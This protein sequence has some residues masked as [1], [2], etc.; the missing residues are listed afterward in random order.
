MQFVILIIICLLYIS[1]NS[2]STRFQIIIDETNNMKQQAGDF[3]LHTIEHF[4]PVWKKM[5]Q[6]WLCSFYSITLTSFAWHSR[7]QMKFKRQRHLVDATWVIDGSQQTQKRA[8]ESRKRWQI[9]GKP[10]PL[11]LA[12]T[13]CRHGLGLLVS[14]RIWYFWNLQGCSDCFDLLS[15]RV[16]ADVHICL[17]YTFFRD[18]NSV[19]NLHSGEAVL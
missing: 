10:E 6:R 1:L 7:F 9:K 3:Y 13:F 2:N 16:I 11:V 15:G 12:V 17:Q 5:L 19:L 18:I 14:V 4:F 8:K